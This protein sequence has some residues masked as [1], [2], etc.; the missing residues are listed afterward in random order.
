M[1]VTR[2]GTPKARAL[3]AELREAREA[4]GQSLRALAR[5]LETNH[6]K[7]GRYESG[8]QVPAPEFVAVYLAACDVPAAE[9]DRVV[10][11]ARDA[12]Q[13]DWLT[14]GRNGPRHE[15]T[16]LIEF[17]RTATSISEV[18]TDLVPGLLQTSAYARVIMQGMAEQER[19]T[20][21]LMR[22]GRREI[23]TDKGIAFTAIISERALTEPIG[24][25]AVMAEQLR[26]IID[27][28]ERPNIAVQVLRAGFT[29]AH[30]AHMGAF[31]HFEFPKASPIVHLEHY[32]SATFLHNPTIAQE[33]AEAVTTLRTLAMSE[34]E[35]AK[36]I[37]N[38]AEEMEAV[39]S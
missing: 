27:M 14:T 11:M 34:E 6:V 4:N 32:Q 22:V 24:G 35:S 30:P 26:H 33:Y 21:V 12:D 25:P 37:A 31:V 38:C 10:E 18:A 5:E 9:R 17:E 36:F 13:P 15:L 23:L 20:R 3:G 7:L 28:T 29:T 2:G 8:S 39:S 19:E 1:A 16:T